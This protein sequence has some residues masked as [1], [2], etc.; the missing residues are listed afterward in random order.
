VPEPPEP[1]FGHGPFIGVFEEGDGVV[2]VLGAVVVLGVVVV[3]GVEL[4]GAAAAPA[5]PAT[6]P[7]VASAPNTIAALS[8]FDMCIGGASSRSMKERFRDSP[9]RAKRRLRRSV[10]VV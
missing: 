9:P 4:V 6:A 3:V 10:G 5:M 7:P 2:G 1:M 8:V